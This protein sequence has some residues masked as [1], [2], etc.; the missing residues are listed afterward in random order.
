MAMPMVCPSAGQ[1]LVSV[2][3][4]EDHP[5][6]D[7]TVTASQ[8]EKTWDLMPL[9]PLGQRPCSYVGDAGELG[10]EVRISAQAPGYAPGSST[11]SGGQCDFLSIVLDPGS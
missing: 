11:A 7:A 3:T 1:I 6:C 2:M 9:P 8:G 10:T 4:D 5:I